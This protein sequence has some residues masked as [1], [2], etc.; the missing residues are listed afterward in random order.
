MLMSLARRKCVVVGGGRVAA[1]KIDGLLHHGAEVTV[2]SPRAVKAIESHAQDGA[3]FW[4]NR[5]FSPQDLDDAFLAVAATN[6]PGTNADVFR[7]CTAR[8]VLCNSVDDPEHCGFFYPSVVRRGS[9]Q[10]AI[11]TGGRSPALAA[12]LRRELEQQFGPEWSAWVEYLGEQR[13]ELLTRKM[14]TEKRRQRLLQFACL[15]AFR[16][17]LKVHYQSAAIKKRTRA[18]GPIAG[19]SAIPTR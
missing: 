1:A 9:L 19:F 12:R 3:L 8:G 5:A 6:S 7:A 14:S 16:A 2:V 15:E 13:E 4:R 11:S 17:F 10:I 18:I